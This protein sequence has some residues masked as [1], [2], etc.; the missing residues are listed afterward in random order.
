[1]FSNSAAQ[2]FSSQSPPLFSNQQSVL[3]GTFPILN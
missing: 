3:S 1:L 2:I